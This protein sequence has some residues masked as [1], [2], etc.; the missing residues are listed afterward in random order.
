M[1]KDEFENNISNDPYR[2]L[3]NAIIAQAYKDYIDIEFAGYSVVKTKNREVIDFENNLKAPTVNKGE[4]QD[5][6]HSHL[7]SMITDIPGEAII[8]MA[9][10]EIELI[11]KAFREGWVWEQFTAYNIDNMY[12]ITKTDYKRMHDNSRQK[13]GIEIL[14]S[15]FE[16]KTH[17]N[18]N[19]EKMYRVY[20]KALPSN[21][22]WRSATYILMGDKMNFYQWDEK[23]DDFYKVFNGTTVLDRKSFYKKS[24]YYKN[25]KKGAK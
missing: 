18:P 2:D 12:S 14:C 17:S 24:K 8:E 15:K 16:S 21:P 13:R 3:G 25:L 6:L 19:D 5:F 10:K 11:R 23:H 7:Y 20:K 1:K 4:I 9:E 22:L